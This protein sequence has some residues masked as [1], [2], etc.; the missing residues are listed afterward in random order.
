MSINYKHLFYMFFPI[1]MIWFVVWGIYF[2]FS[3]DESQSASVEQLGTVTNA[4]PV[5]FSSSGVQISTL[6]SITEKPGDSRS[7][8]K[9]MD[10]GKRDD[11]LDVN[12]ESL[13]SY[14]ADE[15][16]VGIITMEDVMEELLQ[17]KIETISITF[18][19]FFY[20]AGN[21]TFTMTSQSTLSLCL[22]LST[23][24][25]QCIF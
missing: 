20:Y 23:T 4:S 10:R 5:H 11:I 15:E 14:S 21:C 3:G 12:L 25:L 22:A 7:I 6:K 8:L 17:V 1:M 19:F 2:D 13:P 24:W 18:L 9:R 16:V